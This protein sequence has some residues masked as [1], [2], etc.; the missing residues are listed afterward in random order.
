MLKTSLLKDKVTKADFETNV[1][2][3]RVMEL[4]KIHSL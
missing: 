3:R 1:F 2:S 4:S